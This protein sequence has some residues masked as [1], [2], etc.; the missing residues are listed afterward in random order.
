MAI[1]STIASWILQK[2]IHD[3]ELYKKF[4]HQVQYECFINLLQM[5][6]DT[7]WGQRYDYKSISSIEE[8]RKRV[9]IHS[10]HNL[11]PYFTRVR[12]GEK[13]VL[14]PGDIKWFA[15]SSGTTSSKS[16]FIPVSEEALNDCHYK[17]GKDLLAVYY[18][19]YP[20]SEFLSGKTVG[21]AGSTELDEYGEVFTGD[22]SAIIMSNLPMWAHFTK[23]PNLSIVVMNEWKEKLEKIVE[24]SITEDIRSMSGVPSWMLVILR[25]LLEVS[26]K[27]NIKELWPN[28]E[29][30][31]H[32]G[33]SFEPYRKQFVDIC[34][35]DVNYQEVYNASE[36]FIAMQ[37]DFDRDDMLLMLG[38]GIFYEFLPLSELHKNDPQAIDLQDVIIGETYA[39]VISTNAGLWRY[40]IGDTVV[41][42]STNPYRIKINGRTKSFINSVGEEL[43]VE[44]AD[45][46]LL[47][48]CQHTGAVISEYTAAPIYFETGKK[49]AHEWFIEFDKEP[50][51]IEVF[52]EYLDNALKMNNSD[53]EAKR[54]NNMILTKPI[55]HNLAQGSFIKWLDKNNR[56]GGQ[57]KVPRL[58]NNR[59]IVEDLMATLEK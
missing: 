51:D 18:D 57:Y 15:K 5:A 30:I 9:P 21:I 7:E 52:G 14:W 58:S 46:A 42:T 13:D 22:L 2:R 35:S 45:K 29:L 27:K 36:G 23:V 33:V 4:P 10:Y 55:I 47:H 50:A 48:A 41:F 56:L 53:Y 24:H 3:I 39:L 49:A 43:V 59:D 31:V 32:G 17:G 28:F 40:L 8:Y 38:Y 20:D 25:R 37:D 19:A 12:K 1:I 54:Y 11:E 34:G 16:K 6:E 44:N 26:G